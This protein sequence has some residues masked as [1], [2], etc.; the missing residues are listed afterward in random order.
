MHRV[1]WAVK[2]A[3]WRCWAAS[4][5]LLR[6]TGLTP[7]RVDLLHAIDVH[8]GTLAQSALQRVLGVVRSTVSEALGA[9]ERLGCVTRGRRT[10]QGRRVTLTD[11]GRRALGGGLYTAQIAVDD[12]LELTMS[13]DALSWAGRV[14][15]LERLCK[16]LRL[17]FGDA[18]PQALWDWLDYDW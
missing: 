11:K 12:G 4:T 6:R 16:R 7:A 14:I 18:S 13:S 9:L 8:G 15:V 3:H 2:R 1:I 17:A 5:R 10:H